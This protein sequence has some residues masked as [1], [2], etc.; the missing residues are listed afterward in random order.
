MKE[1]NR[2]NSIFNN[3]HTPM[4]IIDSD[5]GDIRDGNLAACNYYGYTRDKLRELNITD[6]NILSQQEVFNEMQK[7]KE[8]NRKYFRFTHRL[9][10]GELRGV[11]VYSGPIMAADE[12]LLFSIIHDIQYKREIEHKILLQESYFK[13]LF[14][15]SPEAIAVLDN[16]FRVISV[17]SSFERIFQYSINEIK[18]RNITDA[19]CDEKLYDESSYFKDSINRGEFV[20]KE[21]LRKRKDG[22]LIEVSFL[23]YPVKFD[24]ENIGIYGIYSDLS[25]VKAEKR[26]Q[27][28]RIQSYIKELEDAKLKAEEAS[29]F[30]TQFIANMTHEIRTPMNGIVGIIEL[31]EDT[32]LT[33]EQ[34]EYFQLLRYSANRLS[35]VIND[36]LDIS[37]IEVGKLELRAV[38]FNIRQLVNN[39]A[40]YYELQAGRKGL[41]L[42]CYV[43]SN[44]PDFLIGDPDKLNQVLF[45][46]LSNAVKFTEIGHIDIEVKMVEMNDCNISINFCISDTGIGIPKE[47]TESIFEDFYQLEMIKNRKHSGA[48]LGLSISRKLVKLMS[49]DIVVS[50]EFGKGSAF[51]FEVTF[52]ISELHNNSMTN[53]EE[54]QKPDQRIQPA[55]NILVVE[56]ES[57]NQKILKSILEK[58]KCNV[59]VA[60]SGK[61]ALELL[62]K[63][64][65]DIILMD[66]YMPDMNGYEASVLIRKREAAIGR[67][68][69]IIAITAAVQEEDRENYLKA[70]IECC[71]AKPC[72]KDQI[73]SAI[74]G[75]LKS[76]HNSTAVCLDLL[77]DRFGGDYELLNDIIDEVV[78]SEYEEEF[79][80]GIEDY[81]LE[82]DPEKLSR[83]IHRFKGSISH[84]QADSVNKVLSDIMACCKNQ[85]LPQIEKL[86]GKLKLEYLRFRECL[87]SYHEVKGKKASN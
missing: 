10:S 51:S 15:N 35:A 27:E 47:K 16:G 29:M 85:D 78:S 22:K 30:K 55:L 3:S 24:G 69:P 67:Y 12:S 26:E 57:V 13:S 34:K 44:I 74:A 66:I 82:K 9:S 81:I 76:R 6:I 7:A 43:D 60:E 38:R 62:E 79:F 83:H 19:I 33:E 45:N 42:N 23:G 17:N 84:F 58:N 56:D 64:L 46:L 28:K 73:F 11:E 53:G 32:L 31:M 68:T 36:V 86:L 65:F 4:L 61:E 77:I 87:M 18:N 25:G 8:E 21:I 71:I 5:T 39:A 52:N 49:S 40:R 80:G 50:S 63:R 70:G 37:K 2:Y 1:Q 72:G 20:R 14:E 75:V 48:G 54:E 59:T 41:D